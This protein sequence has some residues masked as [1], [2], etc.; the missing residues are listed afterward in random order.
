MGRIPF[1]LYDFFGYLAS[2]SL[3]LASIAHV[4]DLDPLR[5]SPSP[6]AAV[7]LLFLAYVVGQALASPAA[8]LLERWLVGRLI[9]SPSD[10]LL[11]TRPTLKLFPAYS[12]PL[13]RKVR[14]RV[15]AQLEAAG[16][17]DDNA[18]AFLLGFA[19]AKSHSPTWQRLQ[20]F[21]A[22]YGF[23]RNVS[24][25]LLLV[26][27]IMAFVREPLLALAA[28]VLAFILAGRYLKFYRLFGQEV[29][30]EFVRGEQWNSKSST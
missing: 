5:Q 8:W 30:L 14:E 24:F 23:A 20:T 27:I 25:S 29:L 26:S 2:G 7:L 11:L 3:L 18:S 17:S 21:Q 19:A 13:P 6:A 15:L 1:S 12:A 4:L 10:Y 22:L 28:G 9:G 16:L